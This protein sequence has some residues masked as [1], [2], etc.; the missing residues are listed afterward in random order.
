MASPITQCQKSRHSCQGVQSSSI[1]RLGN[2]FYSI[3]ITHKL[4][5]TELSPHTKRNT[6]L[7]HRWEWYLF[8]FFEA[9][10]WRCSCR[11]LATLRYHETTRAILTHWSLIFIH[12]YRR[13]LQTNL[14]ELKKPGGRHQ[15]GLISSNLGWREFFILHVGHLL[16]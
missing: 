12:E 7:V 8:I 15:T 2:S 4:K 3:S 9:V 16:V 5:L 1:P 10:V 13:F 14:L 11:A 6:G